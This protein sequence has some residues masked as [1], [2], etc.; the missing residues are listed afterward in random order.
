MTLREALTTGRKRLCQAGIEESEPDVWYLLQEAAGVRRAGYFMNP[1]R[2]MT[3]EEAAVYEDLIEKRTRHIPLQYIIGKQEFMGLEFLVSDAVLIP[4]Q[5]TE[6]LVCEVL[7]ESKGHSVLDVCTGS[8]CIIISL[9]RLGGITRA[10]ACDI[11]GDALAVA[12]ENARRLG[13]SVEFYQGDLFDPVEG[14]FDV[15]VSNPP[16]IAS[17]EIDGLMPEVRD[18]EPRLALDGSGDGLVFYRR[19]LARA[20][21]HLNAGGRIFFEIGCDQAAAVSGLLSEYGYRDIRVVRDYSGLDRVV[22][23]SLAESKWEESNV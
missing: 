9:A 22:C 21:E 12:R 14:R 19:I 23:G 5:D 10:A 1:D 8:G 6:I 11:S 18:Y 15:I 17:G 20:G 7:K 16:Y 4:R 3:P 2:E 13:V